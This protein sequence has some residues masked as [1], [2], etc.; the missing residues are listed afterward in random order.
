MLDDSSP[1][2][3]IKGNI[4]GKSLPLKKANGSIVGVSQH[5][6]NRLLVRISDLVLEVPHQE[7]TSST[8]LLIA[9]DN[10]IYQLH[11]SSLLPDAIGNPCNHL[12]GLGGFLD[13]DDAEVVGLENCASDSFLG[14]AGKC[15]LN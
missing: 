1:D 13:H 11:E 7:R 15:D 12:L 5:L 4:L 3:L 9:G 2:L 6:H 8:L 14:H 10:Q